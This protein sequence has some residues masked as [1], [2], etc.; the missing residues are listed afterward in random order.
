LRRGCCPS[1]AAHTGCGGDYFFCASEGARQPRQLELGPHLSARSRSPTHAYAYASQP[2]ALPFALYSTHRRCSRRPVAR[3][4]KQATR[5]S[6]RPARLA[7][8]QEC[9]L[10]PPPPTLR[11]ADGTRDGAECAAGGSEG[12]AGEI[13]R[14]CG[15]LRPQ[16]VHARRFGRVCGAA[17]VECVRVAIVCVCEK[18][19]QLSRRVAPL[20]GVLWVLCASHLLS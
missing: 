14:P 17:V 13:R 6:R 9:A 4:R 12:A 10:A 11:P 18:Y 15:G 8:A 7:R 1:T 19:R 20:C 2:P 3:R 16:P 5:A